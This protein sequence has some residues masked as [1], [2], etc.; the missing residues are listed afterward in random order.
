MAEAPFVP[1]KGI[2][3]G[4]GGIVNSKVYTSLAS[5]N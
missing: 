1:N 5:L 2:N 4:V 3:H